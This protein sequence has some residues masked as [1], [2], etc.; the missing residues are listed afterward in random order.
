MV[1]SF[2]CLTLLTLLLLLAPGC[3]SDPG[4]RQGPA[5]APTARAGAESLTA[6]DVDMFVAV[7][8]KAMARLEADTAAC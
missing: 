7:R 1:R 6:A 8:A 5:L 2:A 4:E 3:G